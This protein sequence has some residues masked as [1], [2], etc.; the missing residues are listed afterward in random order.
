MP[1][2][3]KAQFKYKCGEVECGKIIRGDK[4]K[5]HC[6]NEHGF[7]F[8]RGDD[9]KKVKVAVKEGDSEWRPYVDVPSS[10]V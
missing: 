4:W 3:L 9:I 7:K 5:W 1:K 10:K 8:A 6:K 2:V